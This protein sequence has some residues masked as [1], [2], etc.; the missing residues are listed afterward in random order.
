MIFKQFLNLPIRW[1]NGYF[2]SVLFEDF[3]GLI[4]VVGWVESVQSLSRGEARPKKGIDGFV[5]LNLSFG[6]FLVHFSFLAK[7]FAAACT[8]SQLISHV[9]LSGKAFTVIC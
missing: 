2:V 3:N 1:V 5:P 6:L 7:S 4:K 9:S 8:T